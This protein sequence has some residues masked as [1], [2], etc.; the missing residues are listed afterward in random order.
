MR[1]IIDLAAPCHPD[2][3]LSGIALVS[4]NLSDGYPVLVTS[5]DASHH[6]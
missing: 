4:K 6:H 2:D 5:F 1:K 3:E